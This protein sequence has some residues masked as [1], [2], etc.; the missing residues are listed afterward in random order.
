MG[1]PGKTSAGRAKMNVLEMPF[2]QMVQEM[3][4]LKG[5]VLGVNRLLAPFN[6]H[7]HYYRGMVEL[8]RREYFFESELVIA[9]AGLR[10]DPRRILEIGTRNGGSLSQLLHMLD[11]HVQREV[12]CF[13]LW[14]EI[15]GPKSVKKNLERL[16]IPTQNIEFITGDSRQT[17]PQYLSKEPPRSFDYVL[18]DGG[19]EREVAAADLR[20][21]AD[22]VAPDGILIFDDIGPESYCLGDVWDAFKEDQGDRFVYYEK[23]HRK[24]IAWAFRRR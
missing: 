21:V 8:A 5:V 7:D 23:R 17:V 1:M 10:L 9:W 3:E 13:D 14:R 6:R 16:C 22:F 19:H 12:V 4:L 20:N 11:H 2:E 15:G 18:V 24:G